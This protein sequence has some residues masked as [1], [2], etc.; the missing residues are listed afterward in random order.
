M[1][2]QG[3]AGNVLAA[4]ASLFFPGL[5]QL[6]QGRILAALLFFCITAVCYFFFVLVI[7]AIIGGLFHL[8][9]IIDAAKF[10]SGS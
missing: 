5:G 4:V 6:L 3:S 9:S 8:W 2:Q 10:K 7:P 1:S